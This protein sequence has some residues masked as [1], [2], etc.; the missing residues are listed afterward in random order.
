MCAW[1]TWRGHRCVHGGH[2]GAAGVCVGH[3][4]G[5]LVCAWGT[6]RGSRCVH[7]A[8][9]GATGVCMGDMEGL[10]VPAWGT[11]RGHRCV[12]AGTSTLCMQA[13]PAEHGCVMESVRQAHF[14]ACTTLHPPTALLCTPQP[15]YFAPP[16]GLHYFAPPNR[17][18]LLPPTA[19][20]HGG[21]LTSHVLHHLA[22]A[23]PPH[24]MLAWGHDEIACPRPPSQGACMEAY[25]PVPSPLSPEACM[26]AGR[27]QT[28]HQPDPPS[29]PAPP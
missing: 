17:T 8:H 15:H 20:L 4:E 29:H 27:S 12:H 9:G 10:L 1:G 11:W 5:P 13:P 16:A 24:M 18:T 6:W 19:G 28:V 21:M 22:P 2:G 14:M 3:M 7:G 23:L 25:P 26:R